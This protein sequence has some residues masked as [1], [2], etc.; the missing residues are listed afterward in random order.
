MLLY[1]GKNLFLLKNDFFE[2]LRIVRILHRFWKKDF[3]F[4]MYKKFR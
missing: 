4:C 1:C 3:L 2:V